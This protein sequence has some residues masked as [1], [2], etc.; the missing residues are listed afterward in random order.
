M[1]RLVTQGSEEKVGPW[2]T[3]LLWAVVAILEIAE[4]K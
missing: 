4:R 3:I 2:T 1:G